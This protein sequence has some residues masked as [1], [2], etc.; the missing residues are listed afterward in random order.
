MRCYRRTEPTRRR[1]R[2]GRR[3][4]ASPTEEALLFGLGRRG[5]LLLL[6]LA[7]EEPAEEA[8]PGVVL[9]HPSLVGVRRAEVESFAAVELG[10]AYRHPGQRYP[11]FLSLESLLGKVV[12]LGLVLR[13]DGVHLL[14]RECTLHETAHLSAALVDLALE[15]SALAASAEDL[16][17]LL[18]H[19]VAAVDVLV[20]V[21]P[22]RANNQVRG[23]WV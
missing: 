23:A 4:L 12:S 21:E 17:L 20:V 2:D 11:A 8:A 22:S 1:R 7:P 13:L 16:L 10:H 5:L 6:L 14:L 3:S 9:V 19:W 18:V 15:I